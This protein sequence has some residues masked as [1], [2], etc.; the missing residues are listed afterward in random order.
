MPDRTLLDR[1]REYAIEVGRRA[2]PS[3][4]NLVAQVALAEQVERLANLLEAAVIGDPNQG[5]PNMRPW[6]EKQPGYQAANDDVTPTPVMVTLTADELLQL[7]THAVTIP[8]T[9]A[10][11][12]RVDVTVVTPHSR[13]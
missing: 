3:N 1:A 9:D 12:R 10:D 6:L 2:V 11:G 4:A 7:L 13:S 5:G 8:G